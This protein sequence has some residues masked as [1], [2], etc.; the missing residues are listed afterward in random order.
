VIRPTATLAANEFRITLKDPFPI[1]L[2]IGMPL[3][4]LP[5]MSGGLLGGPTTAVPGLSALFGFLGTSVVG[6]AFFRDHGWRTWDRLRASGVPPLAIAIGKAAPL[7]VLYA[8]QQVVLLVVGWTVLGM[9]WRGSVAAGVLM[10]LMITVT[11]VSFG[12]LAATLATTI[13]QVNTFTLLGGL[14]LACIGGA[15][16]PVAA[17]P[18]WLRAIAPVS[19]VYWALA[20][21]RGV[22]DAGFGIGQVAVPLAVLAG[23]SVLAIL[24][25]LGR[26][27]HDEE[28]VFYA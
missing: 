24:L 22:I 10:V 11:Q 18:A 25:V 19:P 20:G 2:L 23:M 21:I 15:L 8:C 26:Y 1:V 9:A 5:F 28:K 14:L 12:M 3:V 27:R 13:M 6:L 7:F 17:L 16:T 4:L